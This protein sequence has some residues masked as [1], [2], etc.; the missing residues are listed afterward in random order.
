MADGL[1]FLHAFP[2]DSSMWQPQVSA[3]SGEVPV[4]AVRLRP[5]ARVTGEQLVVWCGVRMAQYKAPRTVVVVD[6]LPRTGTRKVQR[7]RLLPLFDPAA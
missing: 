2:L 3:F 5:K 4:A 1:L 7:D 6:D